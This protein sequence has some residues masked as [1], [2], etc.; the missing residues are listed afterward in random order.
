MRDEARQLVDWFVAGRP[1]LGT[2]SGSFNRCRQTVASLMSLLADHGIESH[3][4]RLSEGQR[5][6]PKAH[7]QWHRLG[8]S[9]YWVHYALLVD[10]MVVDCTARQFDPEADFPSI[11][12]PEDVVDEWPDA[13]VYEDASISKA[14]CHLLRFPAGPTTGMAP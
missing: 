4:V 13:V 6:Y 14:V 5:Y 7:P 3:A 8:S 10:G 12:T 11:R 9:V 2:Q 1:R